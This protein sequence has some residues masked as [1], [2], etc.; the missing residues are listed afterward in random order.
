MTIDTAS[1]TAIFSLQP[2]EYKPVSPA[3]CTTYQDS[4]FYDSIFLVS[5]HYYFIFS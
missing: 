4:T 2:A 1:S 3:W 5:L